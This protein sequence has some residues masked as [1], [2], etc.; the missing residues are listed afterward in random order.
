MVR[1]IERIS[2]AAE[3]DFYSSENLKV[4]IHL[5]SLTRAKYY[6]LSYDLQ[7][8]LAR[9]GSVYNWVY[10]IFTLV[11]CKDALRATEFT[12]CQTRKDNVTSC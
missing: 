6:S 5:L 4:E 7:V 1:S 3:S 12:E 11:L 10:A 9:S 2:Y 8:L